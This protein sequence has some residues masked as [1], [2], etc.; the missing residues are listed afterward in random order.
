[1][2]K[3]KLLMC[4]MLVAAIFCSGTAQGAGA[5]TPK[6][7]VIRVKLQ[8]EMALKVGHAP[9]MQSKGAVT[10]GI[11]PFDRAARDVKAVSIRPM[12]PYVEKFAKQRAKYGLDRWYVINFDE[13]VSPEEARKI[14]AT[15]AGVERSELVTPMSLQEGAKGFRKLDR[16][17]VVKAAGAMPFNDPYLPKQWHYQNFGDIPYSVAGADINLFNAWKTTTGSKDVLVAIIDG[18]VDYTHEDLAANI[19]VNEAELNGKDGV[20][21]DGNGYLDDIYGWNFC[22]NKAKIYP[23]SHGTHVAGTV[24]AVNN[25]GI[26]VAGVAGGDG[27][28]GSGVKMISCQVFDSRSGTAEGDFAA[29]IVYAA[30]KGAT[31]AQCSWGW[32]GDGYYEQAVLDAIDYFTAEARS[33]NM[34]GGLCIFAM[35]NEGKTGN[36]Y[37]GCY[38]KVIGVAAMTSELTPASYSCNG[39]GTDIVAPGGLLDYG[40]AQ[41][42]LSTLPGNEY[43][44]NEG[45]SMAT[46]HVSGVAALVLSKYGSPTFIN[47]TLRTQLLTSVNDF[48]GYGNNSSVEGLF[49]SGYLDA[50]KAVSMNATGAPDAVSDF[51]LTATQDN[52]NVSWKVPASPDN[53]VNN[54]IVYYSTE[55]FTAESDLTKLPSVVVDSKFLNSGD[56][57]SVEL[58][59]L[60]NLTTYYVAVQAVNRWGKASLLSPV[61]SIKTNAGPKMTIAESSLSMTATA[62]TPVVTS[63]LTI[64]NEAEGLLKWAAA[65]RTVSV[66]TQSRRPLPGT[67]RPFQ[68]QLSTTAANLA[69]VAASAE[70]DADDYP[71]EIYSYELL[72]AM[73]GESDKTLPN[74]LA[75]WFKVDPDK[76]PDG[77]NLTDLYFEAP[78]SGAY[79]ADPKISIYKGDVSISNA[80]LITDVKYDFFAYNYN[81]PLKQQ[82]HFAPGESFWVVAHYD[83]GQEG[84]PL[85]MA[86][87]SIQGAASNSF[88]SNDMGKTWVQLSTALKGSIYESLADTFVWGVK[89]RSLNPDWSE[90]LELD[91][92]SGTVKNGETQT[93]TVK[94]DGRK[95]VNGDY[96]MTVNISTNESENKLKSVPVTIAVS[97]NEPSVTVPKVVDFGSMLTGQSKTIVVEVY[98]KGYGSFRGSKNSA[99][100]YSQNIISS[101][102]HFQ[103]PKSVQSGFPARTTTKLELTYAPKEAGSHSGTI[104]FKDA[105]GREV[106][107]L[108]RGVATEPAKLTV[109]PAVVEAG[110]LTLGE[111]PKELSFK[112]SNTGKYPLEYVFPKF[113][114]ETIE[115]A[116]KLHKF[117]YTVSSTLDGYN[118]FEYEAAPALVNAVDIT[119]GFNDKAYISKAISLGFSFP[120]Y[121]KNYDKV[122]VT[123]YGGLLFSLSDLMFRAP[124]TETSVSIQGTGLISAYGTQLQMGPESKVEYAWKDGNFIVNFSN[125]LAV[126]YDTDYAPVSFHISLSP[127]GDIEIF[128]DDYVAADFFQ[129]G[130][131]LFCGINDPELSD[132][133]TVTSADIADYFGSFEPTADNQRYKEFGTGT[134]VRFEAPQTLFVR[135]LEPAS[136]LVA[137][138]ESV[139]VKATVSV[140]SE[141]NAGVTF[142]NIAIVT[143]D[144]APAISAV[145]FNAS[146]NAEGLDADAVV[147]DTEVNFGEVFRTSKLLIPVTVRNTGHNALLVNLPLF[148]SGKMTVANGDAFPYM[149]KPGNSVDV[150]VEV[151][152][153]NE[154][155]ISDVMTIKTNVKDITVNVSGTV[156]GCPEAALTFE[157]ITETVESGTP[158]SKTLEITNSGNEPLVYAF[159]PNVDVKVSVPE[160]NDSKV[161][162]VYGASVDKEAEFKWVDIVSNG[163]GEQNAFRYYNSHDFIEVEL[164]FEFPFYGK[165]YSKMYIYNTGFISFTE[166][167]DDKI[168][169]EP[170]AEFPE[171]SVYNNMIAPYWGLHTMNTTKTAGTYHYVTEDR[172]VVSFMEYG[173]SM[174]NGVCFQVILE[175]DGSFKF[176]YDKFDDNSIIMSPF[177]VAGIC[178]ETSTES[179]KLP[180]RFIAFG[181]AVS[182]NPVFTNTVAP[183]A[184]HAVKV[185]VNTDRMAGVYESTL[186]LT[187]NVPSK[188]KIAIP[189]NVTI[190]GEAK[191]VIP[192][193]VEIENVL[194]YRNTDYTDP[195]VQNGFP[196]A[197]YFNV[198]NE[199]TAMYT[200]TGV[201]YQ[202][203]MLQDPDF[204]EWETPAFMLLAKLPAIDM[205]GN[206]T[207]SYSWQMIDPGL[208]Q[209]AEIG[210]TP[211]EFAMAMTQCEYWMTPGVYDVPVKLTYTADPASGNPVTKTVNVKF[212]VTKAP[213]M[214]LDKEEIRI[215]NATDDHVS[216]ETLKIGNTGE[217]KLTYSLVLDP[218]GVGETDE[219]LG[220]GI[221]PWHAEKNEKS[222]FN[223]APFALY[224]GKFGKKLVPHADEEKNMFDLPSNFDYTQALYHDAMPGSTNA[225]NYGANTEFDVFKTSTAFVAPKSGINISHIYMPVQT[226]GQSNVNIKLELVAG[227]DPEDAEVIGRGSFIAS[228]DPA[229]PQQGRFYV[230]PLDRPVYMNPNE[231]FCLVVTYP[232]GLLSPSFIC[233]KEEPVTNG[234]YMAW[235]EQSGWYDVAELLEQQIGS[236]GYMNTCLETVPGEPWI[237]LINETTEGEIAVDGNVD[238]K[239]QVNAAAAR[240]E[241]GN[242]AVIVIKTNDPNMPKVNFPIHLDMNAS[243]EISAPATKVYAKEGE[244]T[245]VK[246]T[247][248]DP[249]SDDM[250]IKFE[251][252]SKL[253]TVKD[254]VADEADTDAA[255]TKTEDGLYKVTGASHPVTVNVEIKP[256]FGTA[257]AYSF[258]VLVADDKGHR[259]SASV[260]YEVEKVNRAPIAVEG[261]EVE[262]KVGELSEVTEFSELF[263]DPDGDDMT[264]TFEFEANDFA[265][266]YTTE[267]GVVFRGKAVGK[268]TAKVTATD[269]KGMSTPM[270]FVVNVNDGSG[271][272]D[273]NADGSRLVIVKENPVDETLVMS[274]VSGGSLNVEI[275]DAAGKSV[276]HDSVDAVAGEEI[277][278][279]M[280]GNISGLYILRVSNSDESETHRI[281]KK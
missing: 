84:Y 281:F 236:G 205:M 99:G 79:G 170:P 36:Y 249:D 151:P 53:N 191:P 220:G 56:P 252:A 188:D 153:A 259:S 263:T 248:S 250:T 166:R 237:K 112:I 74:S 174:N 127:T 195:I 233:K 244:T 218:T 97:G 275:F 2:Q 278:V 214:S 20:D 184:K 152:T 59:N 19:Y 173:N 160:N 243:P 198:A 9:L 156:I 22:T 148:T 38:E 122:Y 51:E 58:N 131:T 61:K 139:D 103:G 21:D 147:E 172:A 25:N 207:G 92:L 171:G 10:T 1:M 168:W 165:K 256:D 27:T 62:A 280:G 124:L 34:K 200:L 142:N 247:V 65:K 182:F 146:V 226:E 81:I 192:E 149:V 155:D 258:S 261:K 180:E 104:T 123:S 137:P 213:V 199:G 208:F 228:A 94:A 48:Y 133:V 26:G 54:H 163:L 128:Y 135:T 181:N 187:T 106:K 162:Y 158:L 262:V 50:T 83:A 78:L 5:G 64:G 4:I 232:E 17:Q 60:N 129:Q 80:T 47:E 40:E 18:G 71:A 88:M 196:Y 269:D 201:E 89:A 279:N 189:V 210:K 246:V 264:Y 91:P 75:Q 179:V 254:V 245:T 57:C 185:D 116:A 143:N 268:A 183:G 217:Y 203:P 136:G 31:I 138:G 73:I 257:G 12:L 219:D 46:P 37:P 87:T 235:T 273:I 144:P 72:Y 6:K 23:H 14:F 141:M 145:R 90:M 52:I 15:T 176:Q 204:P 194:G 253:A 241:K 140:N 101:S 216:V 121:G 82:I 164:P 77:F 175:K 30:E 107:I 130:S 85:G 212:T 157:E 117:G 209:P 114:D 109:D 272:A 45:T 224:E 100:I 16:S 66:L 177:G 240:L 95:F 255:V 120:Y 190:T 231:E 274:V 266:A 186:G 35:G 193:S 134:A 271:V 63:S 270:T 239:V 223:A 3:S 267:T 93:V 132:Q 24:A 260:A 102:E 67:V 11:T 229:N 86:K 227:N 33:D 113:S 119:S 43:G 167:R 234:R 32:P 7:G 29:A 8:P 55:P 222:S 215:E 44:Y 169:P 68:G 178:D 70:Y 108:V 110:T 13:T 118:S 225:W 211:M 105:D 197:A 126:V 242:K 277:N 238:V 42:V 251:D 96:K 154:G 265:D 206:P 159:T 115:G 69:A 276:Y 125:V 111:E 49:G 76:Y 202:S 230:V 161:S 98:N 221:A 150:M 28:P 41:G 39:P